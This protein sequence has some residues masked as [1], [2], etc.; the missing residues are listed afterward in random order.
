MKTALGLVVAAVCAIAAPAAS[1]GQISIDHPTSFVNDDVV[2]YEA[3]P[4]ETNV[5]SASS[6]FDGHVVNLYDA[7][8]TITTPAAPETSS[9]M[10][11]TRYPCELIDAH[12]ARCI[13]PDPREL[14]EGPSCPPG[15]GCL[16][17]KLAGVSALSISLDD[18]NDAYS[19]IED[20][21]PVSVWV[22]G[23]L[24][25][26]HI[27]LHDSPWSQISDSGGHNVI[28]AGHNS[29]P[30]QY[31]WS[32]SIGGGSGPDEIYADNGSYNDISCSYDV[33]TVVADAI[34]LVE[35]SCENVTRR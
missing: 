11:R 15:S 17:D 14:T 13:V 4:G 7:G 26:D 6:H 9:Y 31:E 25:D 33:D 30:A 28:R 10:G 8:A 12:H 32:N 3:A 29:A 1:A 20:S 2:S 35:P 23:G 19:T 18:G 24:G 34:D 21:D 16:D 27:V 22:S 5:V